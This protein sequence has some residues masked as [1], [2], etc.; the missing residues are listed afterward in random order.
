MRTCT[1]VCS[2]ETFV[3]GMAEFMVDEVEEEFNDFD[4]CGKHMSGP[5]A[6]PPWDGI[7]A[8]LWFALSEKPR[9]EGSFFTAQ[10]TEMFHLN[11]IVLGKSR[12]QKGKMYMASNQ[13][14]VICRS[15]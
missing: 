2:D 7:L 9:E 10:Y 8:G 4:V 3:L 14:S 11:Q 13:S 6:G 5:L 1:V 12:K 15:R